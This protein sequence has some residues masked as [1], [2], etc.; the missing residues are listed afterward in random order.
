MPYWTVDS[1]G[2]AV[3]ARFASAAQGSPNLDE[4]RELQT[5]WFEYATFLPLLR[6]HG[7]SPKREMWEFGG[8]G[9]PAFE[10]QKKF[11]R[12]RYRLLPYVYSL[13]GAVTHESGSI[14][15]PLV[16]D[17]GADKR[18][19][20]IVDQYM[21]GP[22]FLVSPVTTYKSR[23]RTVYLP[24]TRGGWYDF[25]S[26]TPV[27]PGNVGPVDAAAP[28]DRIPLHVRA[29][30]IIPF[31]PELQYTD[32]KPA[33]P[34]TLYIYGGADGAFTI[35]EDEGGNTNYERGLYARVPIRWKDATRTLSIGKRMGTFPGMRAERTFQVV[36]GTRSR[37][38]PFSFTPR[39]DKVIS[40][41][42]EVVTVTID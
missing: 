12:L 28:Y 13:A 26:G 33:D 14:L 7:Q 6:V 2:F 9:S 31:G 39:P 10:A 11:D 18:A 37:P 19:R 4:W 38:A 20:A 40:Y 42:G 1:G 41:K 34:I 16:M 21:F 30:S 8:D 32:E 25:W 35:Y 29:G 3:P 27:A 23:G 36:L 17:F 5:R 24:N 22:A 15:R